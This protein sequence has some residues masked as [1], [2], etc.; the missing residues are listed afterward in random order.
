MR[1]VSAAESA[2]LDRAAVGAG[3]PSRA[4][5]RVAG[6]AA[7]SEIARRFADQMRHGVGVYAGPGNNGGDAWVVAA[8]L[9][10]A[11]VAVRVTPVGESQGDDATAERRMAE[12]LVSVGPLRG[13]ERLIVDGLL[14][15]GA[16]G[17]PRG[18]IA[19]AV[20]A[21]RA[22]RGLG[23]T[24]VA[25]D[26][27]S[28]LDATTGASAGA[29]QADLTLT[30]GTLKRGLAIARESAGAIAVLDIGLPVV[31]ASDRLPALV[32][33]AFVRAHVPPIPADANKGTRR[34]LAIVGS[35]EGMA[36]ASILAARAAQSS[37]IGLVRLFVAPRN[38]AVV[39]A[40]AFES[41]AHS[42]PTDDDAA[43]RDIGEWAHA[44][45]LGPGLGTSDE[46]R[47]L[48]ERVLRNCALPCVIDADGLNIFAG[49]ADEL[50][51]LLRARPAIVTPHPAEFGRL[52]NISLP[53]VLDQRYDIGV[54]LAQ[55]LRATVLLKG[56]PTV[57]SG[58]DGTRRV[59]ARGTSVLATGGSGDIL[60]G[61]VATLLAQTLD[62]SASAACGA[63]AHGA[64]AE[65]ASRGGIRGV[66]LDD[67]FRALLSVWN[68]PPSAVRYPVLAEL[69]A[70]DDRAPD[71][72]Q[73]RLQA[74]LE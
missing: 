52:T 33:E 68:A 20:A 38:V 47:A 9:A 58:P 37:G 51:A 25:L 11:G 40:T 59:S 49:C 6:T 42:W 14:G 16:S 61:I 46:A 64:A 26:V 21:I 15:T 3:I 71:S 65:T 55:R 30:F 31:L 70:V 2:A 53:T 24:I 34:R 44:L 48:A 39:Q 57:V 66:V 8:A 60:S 56:V 67:V 19:D 18:A 12:P 4:L 54:T 22:A 1:V 50:A 29:L 43:R 17:P 28:G 69:S 41:I 72:E 74:G 73:G 32:D 10:A 23:A 62:P 36:G 63:W 5:M 7:A 35:A 13:T 27:P 45:L